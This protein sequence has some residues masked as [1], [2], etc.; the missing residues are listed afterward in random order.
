[1][2]KDLSIPV[3]QDEAIS[4]EPMWLLAWVMLVISGDHCGDCSCSHSDGLDV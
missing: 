2:M 3:T 1:M 4:S